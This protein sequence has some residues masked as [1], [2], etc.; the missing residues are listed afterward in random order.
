MAAALIGA[1]GSVVGGVVGGGFALLAARGQWKR[2]RATAQADRSHQA[3]ISIAES[4]ASMQDALTTWTYLE[5]DLDGLRAA[6]SAFSRT[7]EVQSMALTDDTLRQRVRT[8][9]VLLRTVANGAGMRNPG[10]DMP[11]AA[12]R[13]ADAVIAAL[14]A[15]YSGTPLPPYE[16]PPR[17]AMPATWQPPAEPGKNERHEG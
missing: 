15:H 11:G 6:I 4:I 17:W 1:G 16:L 3:A 10:H 12:R 14:Q 9:L 8:H 7:A 13:D 2:D 5:E